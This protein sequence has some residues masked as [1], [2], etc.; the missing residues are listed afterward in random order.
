M[1]CRLLLWVKFTVV[2][3]N[4]LEF[5]VGDIYV[6]QLFCHLLDHFSSII[7]L[8]R[9]IYVNLKDNYQVGVYMIAI[10]LC[11]IELN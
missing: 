10:I 6:I 1:G 3:F 2:Y 8:L 4:E 7:F 9:G 11:E 5:V